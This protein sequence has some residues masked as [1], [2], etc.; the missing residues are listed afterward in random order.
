[1]RNTGF[2]KH[3]GASAVIAA[4]LIGSSLT[5]ACTQRHVTGGLVGGA[6]VGGAYE[7]QNK[8]AL[9]DLERARDHGPI[10]EREYRRRREESGT[11]P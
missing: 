5:T 1:M 2:K 3:P 11:A 8:E 6:L 9:R 7:Y 4:A 10:S